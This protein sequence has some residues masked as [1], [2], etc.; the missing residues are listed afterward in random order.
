[1]TGTVETRDPSRS[2]D[3][4]RPQGRNR[5]RA[6]LI[7]ALVPII[8]VVVALLIGLIFIAI[9][10]RDPAKAAEALWVANF[11]SRRAIGEALVSVTPLIFTGL[12]VAFAFR[13]GLF[14]IGG[15]G[16]YIVAQLAAA[17][18]GYA[19][20]GLPGWLHVTVAIL[21]GAL[22]GGLWGAIPGLL[23]AYRGVHEVVNT[24]MMNYIALYLANYLIA[25]YLKAPG[26]LPVTPEI[27]PTARLAQILPPSRLH[28][29][30]FL[31]LGAA[32]LVYLLL[33]HTRWGYEIRAVGHN[34]RAAEYAGIDVPRNLALAML[35]SGA[36]A[37]LAGTVQV[38]GVQRAFYDPVGGFVGYGF[39][40]IAVA[41]LG[42]NHP[43]G[44]VLAALLFGILDRAAPTMQAMAQ[45]PKATIWVVQATVIL[46]VAADQ[47]IRSLFKRRREVA[48]R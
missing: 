17:V 24:I 10:G 45:V 7:E 48:A 38:L 1:M 25:N 6:L 43:A 13:A 42:R 41:L 46:L 11:G 23:K 27:L 2:Q 36:L 19:I 34:P 8:A 31:A 16:Q 18:A 32:V 37:G 22:A 5:L 33:W 29:G 4:G 21:A 44:V 28:T 30:L 26:A 40:G 35:I 39:D 20:T 15:E 14:N 47:I 9:T 3:Q 12:S